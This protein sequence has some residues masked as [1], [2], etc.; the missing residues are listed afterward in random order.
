MERKFIPNPS[1][2]PEPEVGPAGKSI[3]G[4]YDEGALG[5]NHSP[6]GPYYDINGNFLGTD[7]YGFQGVIHITTRAAFQKHVQPGRR[8][9]NSK[10]LRADPSTQS[11]R[12]I[13]DLPLSAQS[14]IYTHV[15][16][17]FNYIKLDRLYK[18]KISIRGFGISYFKGNTRVFPGYN[19][20]ANYIR[21]GTTHHGR[22]IKVT[23]KDGKYSNDLYTVESIW[24]QLGVH[25]YHGHGVHRDS[26][27]KKLGGTHWKAYFRQYKH[28]STYN[29]LPPELQQEI[30][31]RI[32]EY[33]EIEDPALYQRTYGKK[34]RRR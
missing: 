7:E 24:N 8:Y 34:K 31:D 9:A 19:D 16:S 11:I 33:L 10:G 22:L 2:D 27:D 15:L 29:K 4:L 21:H 30:K 1:H 23:T 28:K 26:G 12:K 25:E 17:R 18:R 14:K 5:L 3:Q 6:S 32:K 20:P 13:Q